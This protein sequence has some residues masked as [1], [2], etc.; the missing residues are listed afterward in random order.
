L[1]LKLVHGR[2]PQ[3]SEAQPRSHSVGHSAVSSEY[4]GTRAVATRYDKRAFVYCGRINVAAI[5]IW[6]RDAVPHDFRDTP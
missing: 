6:L 5:R 4:R 2:P 1:S 3:R